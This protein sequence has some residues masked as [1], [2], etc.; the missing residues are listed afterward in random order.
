MKTAGNAIEELAA[1]V[2]GADLERLPE[3]V[4]RHAPWVFLDVVGAALAG[5]S[6]PE[7][8]S[9]A[10]SQLSTGEGAVA[11][12]LRRGLP[13][14]PLLTAAWLNGTSA[15]WLELDPAH[16]HHR[17]HAPAH[18]MPAAL[19]E[20]QRIGASGAEM[21]TAFV[22]GC[23]TAYRM[24]AAITPRPETNAHGT[25]GIVGA[26]AAVA[27]LR[28]LDPPATARALCLAAH[29][30]LAASFRASI[31]GATVRHAYVGLAAQLA[32]Q[33]VAMAQAGFEPLEDAAAEVF[34]KLLGTAFDASAL[35]AGLGSDFEFMRDFAKLHACC[36]HLYP[37]PDAMDDILAAGPLPSP[38]IDRVIV[39]TYTVASRLSEPVPRNELAARFSIPFGIASRVLRGG[40]LGP[41]AFR[42]PAL[43]DTAVLALAAR[44]QV[45]EDAQ[46][47]LLFPAERPAR[48]EIRLRDGTSRNAERRST[49]GDYLDPLSPQRRIAKFDALVH[50]ILGLRE[51]ARLRETLLSLETVADTAFLF[52]LDPVA[53]A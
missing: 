31:A 30:P 37:A 6:A 29:L 27:R 28:R 50:P 5:S 53:A 4:R 33:A 46:L 45:R 34:G 38:D 12:V 41:D 23:E 49:R 20:A 19:A 32:T 40:P 8:G 43:A 16:R 22:A 47:K 10:A 35:V 44:V 1:F 42:P 24:G 3:P 2:A 25:W 14:A 48:V 39:D 11:T 52:D 7:A 13:Q 9:L 15:V 18:V 26:A 36:H 17:T 51:A 21:L